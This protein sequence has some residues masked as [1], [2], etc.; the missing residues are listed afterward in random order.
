MLP[1]LR[2]AAVQRILG[3]TEMAMLRDS[4]ARSTPAKIYPAFESAENWVVE[5]PAEDVLVAV[6]PKT[7]TGHAALLQ[8]LEYAHYYYGSVLY[9]SR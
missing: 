2:Y 1:C 7:F 5:P 3:T 8:A 4:Q 6:E 9:L